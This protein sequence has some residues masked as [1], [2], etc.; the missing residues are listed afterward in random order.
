[1]KKDKKTILQKITCDV[2]KSKSLVK[3][4]TCKDV[5]PLGKTCKMHSSVK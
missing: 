1:M 2:Y 3:P 4:F 5:C